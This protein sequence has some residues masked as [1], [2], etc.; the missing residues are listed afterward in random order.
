MK[1]IMFIDPLFDAV[2]KGNKTMT[3]RILPYIDNDLV[4]GFMFAYS[5]KFCKDSVP[6]GLVRPRYKVG[7]TVYLKEPIKLD[8]E[9][10]TIHLK[11]SD[12]TVPI[13]LSINF[14]EIEKFMKLQNRSK[15]GYYPK[16]Y[17]P[18]WIPKDIFRQIEITGVRF[19]RLHGISDEDCM[20]EGIHDHCDN[21]YKRINGGHFLYLNGADSKMYDTQKQAF[22]ALIDRISGKGTW[23]SN[24]YVF[25]YDF[26]LLNNK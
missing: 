8:I 18:K 10:K 21:E 12:I 19:N 2:I 13:E 7:E 1:G 22:A 5:N 26:K 9:S 24:P 14:L 11:Y 3:R 16:M 4:E 25:A 17:I 23:D 15:S 20:K 6:E